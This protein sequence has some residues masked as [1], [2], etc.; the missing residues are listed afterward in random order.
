M[1]VNCFSITFWFN[2]FNEHTKLLNTLQRELNNEYEKFNVVNY[3]DNLFAPVITAINNEKKTNLIVSQIN[4]QYNMDNVSL[5]DMEEFKNMSLKLFDILEENDILVSHC[6][7]Y[8][9]SEFIKEDA[10]EYITK[11]TLSNNMFSEDLVDV[12][13][14]FGKKHEDLFYKIVTF[15]NKKQFK[16]PKKVDEFG[17]LLPMALISWNSILTENELIEVTYEINDK[18]LFDFTKDYHTTE[19]YLNKMLY[20]FSEYFESDIKSILE[21]GKF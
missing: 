4:L 11:N 6:E 9:N 7:I 17:R 15:I 3:S 2:I 21:E 20:V 16:I 18:Y 5:K 1:K 19:F 8:N 14:R 10:L 12:S 13:L